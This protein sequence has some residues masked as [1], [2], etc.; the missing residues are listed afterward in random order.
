MSMD[1]D[2]FIERWRGSGGSERANFQRF[3]SELTQLIGAEEPKVAKGDNQSKRP[4][5]LL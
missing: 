2:E 4:A 1:A 3:A 5:L